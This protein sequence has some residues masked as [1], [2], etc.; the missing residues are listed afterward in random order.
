[1]DA[2]QLLD[3]STSVCGELRGRTTVPSRINICVYRTERKV[4]DGHGTDGLG[5][6]LLAV[7][8]D[9]SGRHHDNGRGLLVRSLDEVMRE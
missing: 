1:V 5:L 2:R 3:L 4:M 9:F 6:A 7:G 8:F